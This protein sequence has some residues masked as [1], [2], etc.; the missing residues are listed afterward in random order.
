LATTQIPAA[1]LLP[2][3]ELPAR[4]QTARRLLR[5]S[6]AIADAVT[7]D[8]VV[9]AVVNEVKRVLSAS[10][11]ALWTID[12]DARALR[13]VR[14]LGYSDEAARRFELVPLDAP[15]SSFPALDAART[16]AAVYIDSQAELLA[17]YPH[18]ATSMTPGLWQ[19]AA[20]LPVV[21]SGKTVGVLAFTIDPRARDDGAPADD[22]VGGGVGAGE[23]ERNFLLLVA[24]YAGQAVE[25]L[26]LLDEERRSR[27]RAELLYELAHAVIQAD[28]VERVFDIALEAIERALGAARSSILVYDDA[29]VMRFRAWRNLSDAYR[30]AVDGHSPWT[31]DAKE[32]APILVD[33]V[34]RDE[35][36]APYRPLFER[37]GIGALAFVP[38]VA[39]G[40]L[41]GKFMVYYPRARPFAAHE[42]DLARAIADHVAAAVARFASVAALERTVRFHEMFTGVLGH[43]LRNPLAAIMTAG[44][45]ALMRDESGKLAKPLSRVMRSSERMARMI[46][47]LL[48]FTRARVGS[49]IPVRRAPVD[50]VGTLQHVID[51]I[52]VANPDRTLRFTHD[53][54]A[55][56]AWDA[57]RLAQAFSNLVA[58]AVQHGDVPSAA[59]SSGADAAAQAANGAQAI[60]D[61]RL[62]G[63]LADHVVVTVHNA[64]AVPAA[65]VPR[66]F[67]PL[68]RSE[69]RHR[70][71]SRGL[72]LGLFITH[73]IVKAH[74]GTIAL[75]S[76]PAHGTTFTVTLPRVG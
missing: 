22:E 27:L 67:E 54:D 32:P 30:A 18:L 55:N 29:G 49:G 43:D 38:L 75:K 15:G 2:T 17:L 10:S 56:G 50:L 14:A 68:A 47:Q 61:V 20:A 34:T 26:R 59:A 1:T 64:G 62:D 45:V 52:D 57:D 8:Q 66:M 12:E 74:G 51:E 70:E 24:R 63:T 35:A 53:G 33:D 71:G 7:R 76:D 48:D 44:H 69:A 41:L 58:N 73:E 21:A 42:I 60:V 28:D 65:L 40:A 13:L 31:R 11:A 16:G 3:L 9:D 36:M 46:D 6:G 4:E 23:E 39:G 19:R 25:R 72:G 37:E 5:I